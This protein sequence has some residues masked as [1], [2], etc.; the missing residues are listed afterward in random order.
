[1][2]T[3][4]NLI[5][6]LLLLTINI[7]AQLSAPIVESV[8]GGRINGIAG[9]AKS[10]DTS[11][12]FIST[13]SAN[14]I[15][16]S[17]IFSNSTTPVFNRFY[18]MPGVDARANYGANIKSIAAHSTSGNVYFAVEN[19]ILYTNPSTHLVSTAYSGTGFI[20]NILIIDDYLYFTQADSLHFGTLGAVG[21][22]TENSDSP[23]TFTYAGNQIV[24]FK[25]PINEQLYIFT[26]GNSPTLYKTSDSYNL[27]S[28]STTFSNISL[29]SLSTSVYWRGFGVGPDARLFTIGD[30]KYF[31]Y[32][33]DETTWTQFSIPIGGVANRTIAFSGDSSNYRV[34]ASTIYSTFKGESGTWNSFGNP[35]GMETHP[36]DG[37]VFIDP[38]N[39][40]IVYLTT[41]QGLG[42]SIDKGE[43]IF[44]INDGIEAVQVNDFSMIT[45]KTSAWVAAKSG[46]RKVVNYL[47]T[48]TWTNAIF[49]NN[50]GS[51]YYSIEMS[52][53]DTNR[54]FAGN[55]RIYKSTNNGNNW[56][57]IF[58]PENAP[59]NFPNTGIMANAIEECRF[60]PNIVMAG[61]EIQNTNKGG[62]FVSEDYG[63]T[64]NQIL[65]ETTVIG[66]DVDVADIVFNYEG[67]DTVA[68]IGAIYDLS[69]PQGRSIYR[70]VKSGG[71]WIATQDMD[72]SGTAVGYSITATIQDLVVTSTSDTIYATGT[73]AGIN[74]P[75]TYYKV[76]SGTNLWTT[77]PTSGYPFA[78]G[79][80]STAITVGIDTIYVAVDH[81]IYLYPLGGT[82]WQLGYSYP[83]GT[84]INFLYFDELLAGTSF[85]L[86]GH[87]GENMTDVKDNSIIPTKLV[88][89]QN[90]P[91]PF[92]P[93]TIINYN[94]PNKTNVEISIFN[95]LGQKVQT[96]INSQ[97]SAGIYNIKFNANNFASGVYI[98]QIKADNILI[99]KKMMLVK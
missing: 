78:T 88:L 79:K 73:D 19:Q 68:Y 15:F 67:T 42:A 59:Y 69:L 35:G 95:I 7:F 24:L 87:I 84:E 48:P 81:E 12:I 40:N 28:S 54:V 76:L 58:T 45:N 41:D 2:T 90:Y 11:R 4:K 77:M 6:G 27:L 92:N 46:L 56:N 63:N 64:W 96:L 34:F 80:Q 17:D 36:N 30:D 82:Q 26:E 74:H 20:G 51:P 61:F 3:I 16:Y 50:D 65:L 72:A 85:G 33:D 94:V 5:T 70:V 99:S 53:D 25:N 10:I 62:L 91:N 44:E 18:V 55:L 49:P 22:F 38:I 75:I 14:S 83:V 97:H 29:T 23:I 13:E 93:E 66:E 57:Q 47:T 21:N 37:D 32:S 39:T 1:M 52:K 8:Y 71:S 89:E 98:Y 60:S 31:A 43:T 9:F 86:Y